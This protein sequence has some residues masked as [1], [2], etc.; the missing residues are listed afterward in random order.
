MRE[1]HDD[2]SQLTPLLARG[3]RLLRDEPRVRDA[4][5]DALVDRVAR[6]AA[7]VRSGSPSPRVRLSIPMA[8]A[9]GLACALIGGAAA[10]VVQS[11][12]RPRV[13]AAVAA[14]TMLLPVRF[15]VVAPNAS[16]VS[17][18]GDFNHWNPTR[19]PMRRSAD[20]RVWEVE[21]R[22]PLGRYNY[23]LSI[24]GKVAPDP[25][26]PRAGDDDFGSPNSVLMVRGS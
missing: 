17:V 5:R 6:E 24:D 3:A 11:R 19:L 25:A 22:L 7:P 15:S 18:V 4:W 13:E 26:A 10:T 8:I 14:N 23:A 16:T 1:H 2:D 20:G 12:S 21:V 9:A